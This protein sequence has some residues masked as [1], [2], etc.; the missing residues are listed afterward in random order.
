MSYIPY[1][2]PYKTPADIISD[3]KTK[4][5]SFIDENIAEKILSQINYY[6]FKIYLHPLLDPSCPTGKNYRSGEF[7]EDAVDLY[8]FDEQIRCI[9]FRVIARIEIKLRSRLDHVMCSIDNNPFWYLDNQWFNIKNNNTFFIDSIRNKISNEFSNTKEEYAA[10]YKSKYYNTTHDNFKFLPPFWIAS[11]FLSIG[12]ISKIYDNLNT[13]I[14]NQR[15]GAPLDS[16]ASEFGAPSFK[17]L[18]SWLRVLR[19]IRNRCA[20]HGRLWNANLRAP[21][22]IIPLLTIP[23]T[24]NNRIYS[25]FAMTHKMLISLGIQDIDLHNDLTVLIGKYYCVTNYLDSAG[26]PA[27]WHTDHF[28]Q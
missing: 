12:T 18:C 20:H 25:S 21:S 6:H 19:D 26:F 9:L 27:T 23:P 2:K 5:L 14:I 22:N 28:W 3:L 10:H 11:E 4:Q 7:F 13:L 8:R 15:S 1:V 24:N 17:I 16:M